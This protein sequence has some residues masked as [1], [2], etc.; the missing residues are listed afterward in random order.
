MGVKRETL[1]SLAFTLDLIVVF[2]YI[3]YLMYADKVIKNEAKAYNRKTLTIT[4]FT[5]KFKNLPK[6]SVYGDEF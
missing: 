6:K 5:L 4:D 1:T 3:G 2:V